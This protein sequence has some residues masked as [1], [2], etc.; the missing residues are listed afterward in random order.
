MITHTYTKNPHNH[1]E[2]MGRNGIGNTNGIFDHPQKIIKEQAIGLVK[3][4]INGKS[5]DSTVDIC[6]N[7]ERIEGGNCKDQNG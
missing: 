5:I 6:R 4:L 1:H 3:K 7:I 2:W